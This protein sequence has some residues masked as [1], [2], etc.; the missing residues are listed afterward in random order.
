[1]KRIKIVAAFIGLIGLAFLFYW[2]LPVAVQTRLSADHVRYAFGTHDVAPVVGHSLSSFWVLLLIGLKHLG[3]AGDQIF[4]TSAALSGWVTLTAIGLLFLVAPWPAVVLA[5]LAPAVLWTAVI[6][7][8]MSLVFLW[9]ALMGV[10]SNLQV[11]YE[12]HRRRWTFGA[13]IDGIACSVTPIAWVLV[14]GRVIRLRETRP[15]RWILF[16]VGFSLH[17]ATGLLLDTQSFAAL[18]VVVFLNSWRHEDWLAASRILLVNDG[19]EMKIALYST[20]GF[21]MAI[22]MGESWANPQTRRLPF[23]IVSWSILL[24][25]L[26]LRPLIVVAEPKPHGWQ[27]AHPGWNTVL[28]DFAANVER[29]FSAPAV[30]FVRSSTEEA[31]VRYV[32]EILEKKPR[33]SALRLLNLF[34]PSTLV[35]IKSA[36]PQFAIAPDTKVSTFEEFVENVIAPNTKLGVV[37]WLDALPDRREGFEIQFLGTGYRVRQAEGPTKFV[38]EREALKDVYIRAQPTARDFLSARDTLEIEVF[39]RYATYHLAVAHIIEREKKTTDWERRA[40]GEYDAALRKVQWLSIPYQKVCTAT[41]LEEEARA[42]AAEK[43]GQKPPKSEPLDECKESA[44]FHEP[45]K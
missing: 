37:F 18:P 35:R 41:R 32:N 28:E 26:V 36:V 33:I 17:F 16:A 4:A 21:L 13:V 22:L 29:S 10:F 19:G 1:M 44:W 45:S 11:T 34:E 7:N 43:A 30:A 42:A 20:F 25:P 6:P 39:E 27:L 15:L 2:L 38:V 3:V 40:R 23:R 9:L 31:A 5:A 14:I 8:G 24:I 12:N